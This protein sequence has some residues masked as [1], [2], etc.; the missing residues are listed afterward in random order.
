MI[1]IE[2]ARTTGRARAF[3]GVGAASDNVAGT[4]RRLIASEANATNL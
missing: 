1:M 4:M 3:L 2:P